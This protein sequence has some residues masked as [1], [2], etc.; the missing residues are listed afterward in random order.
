[1]TGQK[2]QRHRCG[3][4]ITRADSVG[5]IH[6]NRWQLTDRI[7]RDNDSTPSPASQGHGLQV[8]LCSQ[9]SHHVL[10]AAG[11]SRES[12]EPR[13]FVIVELESVCQTQRIQN[14]RIID[15]WIT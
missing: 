9:G 12:S 5:D 1:M 15:V 8:V 13:Q 11:C 2:P 7:A 3:K 10:I 14:H 6:R 4:S